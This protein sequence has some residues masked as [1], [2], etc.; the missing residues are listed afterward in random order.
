MWVDVI[1]R[2]GALQIQTRESIKSI[3]IHPF[4]KQPLN[5]RRH[6]AHRKQA[7]QQMNIIQQI[8]AFYRKYSDATPFVIV[9]IFC[10]CTC[11]LITHCFSQE[12]ITGTLIL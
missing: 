11:N 4:T 6:C 9:N 12:L 5:G 2:C 10:N 8:L 1:S 7:K 3:R